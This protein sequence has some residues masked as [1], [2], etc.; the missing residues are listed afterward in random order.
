MGKK[1]ELKVFYAL[2]LPQDNL[3]CFNVYVIQNTVEE[4]FHV[5]HNDPIE[6]TITHSFTRQ[7]IEPNFEAVQFLEASSPNP[8]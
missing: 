6:A 7:D 8:R 4:V 5:H 1:I 2:K 3:D